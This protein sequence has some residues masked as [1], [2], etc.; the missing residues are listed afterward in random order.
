MSYI[1]LQNHQKRKS[2]T[3]LFLCFNVLLTFNSGTGNYF[4]N[5]GPMRQTTSKWRII[6]FLHINETHQF[7]EAQKLKLKAL[8]ENCLSMLGEE[9]EQIIENHNLNSKLH[10]AESLQ[11]DAL[12]EIDE[13]T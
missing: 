7:L 6:T 9:C 13:L 5:L 10:I 1:Q 3:R 2:N 4:K 12:R 11:R 8:P